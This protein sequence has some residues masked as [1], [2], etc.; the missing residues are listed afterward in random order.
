[1]RTSP[2][3]GYPATDYEIAGVV[4]DT[5]Y[6]NLRGEI[7][8]MTFAPASQF[9]GLG[10]WATLMIHTEV[11]PPAAIAAIQRAIAAKYPDSVM[12]FRIFRTQIS[13]RLVRERLMA[14]LSGFFGLLAALLA[15]VGLYG[16]TSYLVARRRTEIGIRLALGA[17]PGQVLTMV[18]REAVRLIIIGIVIGV[19]LALVAGRGASPLLFGLMPCHPVTLVAACVLLAGVAACASCL[20]ALRAAK[21]DPMI[22]LRHE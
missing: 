7:P 19:V 9:P 22:A 17:R 10:P 11:A 2:E 20:P 4:A 15:M 6:S 8:P 16:V 1:V 5:K 14:M 21:L 13:D 12:E 18:M 3:P